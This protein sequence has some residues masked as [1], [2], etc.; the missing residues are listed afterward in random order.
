MVACVPFLSQSLEGIALAWQLDNQVMVT[1][2]PSY[3]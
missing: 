2:G 3:P 1:D